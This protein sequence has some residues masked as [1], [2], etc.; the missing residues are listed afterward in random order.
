MKSPEAS[1]GERWA[2]VALMSEA[3]FF[4]VVGHNL[5]LAVKD[6][7]WVGLGPLPASSSF[8]QVVAPP[9]KGPSG[10]LVLDWCSEGVV[11]LT[12]SG[13][14]P[15]ASALSRNQNPACSETLRLPN[16]AKA[17]GVEDQSP[18]S[19]LGLSS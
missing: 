17:G 11:T 10:L 2:H 5:W 18:E 1:S 16:L 13:V 4:G 14:A 15:P 9:L 7:D 8:L 6:Y 12:V 3:V 19:G